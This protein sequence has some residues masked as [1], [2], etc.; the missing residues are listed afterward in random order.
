MAAA[1]GVCGAALINKARHPDVG[2]NKEKRKGGDL[3]EEVEE[4]VPLWST[5]LNNSSRIFAADKTI[6]DSKKVHVLPPMTFTRTVGGEEEE[7]EEEETVEEVVEEVAEEVVAAA[8]Q[9]V[10]DVAAAASVLDETP[11]AI[12]AAID[13]AVDTA[14]AAVSSSPEP[15]ASS[16]VE[17]DDQSPKADMS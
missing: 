7:E 6:Q 3:L 8:D 11:A 14:A 4:V 9:V 12:N 13:A 17:T 15:A 5:S 16:V 1:L 2:W 10:D